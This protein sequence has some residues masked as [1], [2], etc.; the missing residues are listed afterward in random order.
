[1]GQIASHVKSLSCGGILSH[2][3]AEFD[4]D[5]LW[6][7]SV[8]PSASYCVVC[9]VMVWRVLKMD[10]AINC[11]TNL[12]EVWGRASAVSDACYTVILHSPMWYDILVYCSKNPMGAFARFCM[13]RSTSFIY[14]M[15]FREDV[16]ITNESNTLYESLQR[17]VKRCSL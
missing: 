5:Y 17:D 2:K 7:Q 4:S 6:Q 15:R 11:Y 3:S 14:I 9:I 10:V 1:M 13:C 12:E 16:H 8:D